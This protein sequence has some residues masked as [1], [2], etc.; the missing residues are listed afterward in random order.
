MNMSQEQIVMLLA[1][2]ELSKKQIR[3]RCKNPIYAQNHVSLCKN[4]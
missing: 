2:V 1:A 3:E 4:Q